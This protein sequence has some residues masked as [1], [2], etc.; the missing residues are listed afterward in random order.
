[1]KDAGGAASTTCWRSTCPTPTIVERMSGRRVHVAS[2]RTYHIK[3]NPPKVAGKDDVTGETLIQRDDDREETVQKRLAVYHAQTEPLI[4]Y[5]AKWAA[6]GDAARADVPPGRRHGQRRGGARRVPRRAAR[7]AALPAWPRRSSASS[8]A[9]RRARRSRA[10]LPC[11]GAQTYPALEAVVVA[12]SGAAHPP[13]PAARRSASRCGSSRAATP[14][15]RPAAANAGI[16]AARGDMD[17]VPRRRRP[18]RSDARRGPRRRCAQRAG[19]SVVC[20]LARVRLADGSEQ[21][22]GQPF[23]LTR[24]LRAQFPASVDGA[25]RAHAARRR[26]P[27]RRRVR[28]HAGLGFLPADGAA[29]D[30][31]VDRAAHVRVA[32][33]RGHVGHRRRRQ[34]ATTARFARYRDRIYAKWRAARDALAARLEPLLAGAAAGDRGGRLDARRGALR[35]RALAIARNEPHALNMLAMLMQRSGRGERGDRAAVARRDACARTSRR[36]CSTSRSWCC[37]RGE[38][39]RARRLAQRRAATRD[40]ATRRR[41]SSSPRSAPR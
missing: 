17:H 4:A 15:S 38:H 5:Y 10:A 19:T 39:E 31:P 26:L 33:R 36:S 34:P 24:A 8:S 40:P 9:A 20:S 18:D 23:A 16:D 41:R 3:F 35:K 14:L 6:S 11:I 1:M 30:V 12:A 2:G 27:L 22:W 7:L 13:L 37:E 25:V 29:R 21:T 32:R 28:H